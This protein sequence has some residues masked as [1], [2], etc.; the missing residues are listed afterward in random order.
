MLVVLL[1]AAFLQQ[2]DSSPPARL[3]RTI[4][5]DERLAA[6]RSIRLGDRLIV[7]STSG[8]VGDTVV[9][10]AIVRR[11]PDPSEVAR[12]QYRVR[13]HLDELQSLI[14]YG[15]RVDRFAVTAKPGSTESAIARINDAAFGF[16]A[17][18]SRDI[19]IE[20]SRTFLVVTR[21]HRAIGV[22]TIV[23]SAIFLLCIMLL[24]V[25]ER[26][27]DVAALRLM[28]I[29]ARSIVRSVMVEAA[30]VALV[31]SV[32]GVLIG[33]AAA[34]IINWHYR[35]VYRTPLAFAVVTP[36]IVAFAVALSVLLGLIAG[37]L[38][39]QRLVRV[40]AL[41]LITGRHEE[42]VFAPPGV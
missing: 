37:F 40:P 20:T 21:F 24:K 30:L 36:N 38:A 19:A 26:R 41:E 34:R 25:D 4:A 32:A 8:G 27:R 6:D 12:S 23:A 5:I 33:W 39:A 9:V 10:S 1:A 28:G 17:H 13:M 22:I 35:D 2:I 31:G 11:Q 15:D 16:R 29:S 7:S 14:D 3:P 42:R 18:R